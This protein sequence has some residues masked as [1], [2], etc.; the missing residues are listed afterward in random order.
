[1]FV[2]HCKSKQM[3]RTQKLCRQLLQPAMNARSEIREKPP[4]STHLGFKWQHVIHMAPH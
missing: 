3:Q 4:Q 2:F 1:M